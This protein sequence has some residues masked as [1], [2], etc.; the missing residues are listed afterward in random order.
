MRGGRS[1]RTRNPAKAVH[2]EKAG[3]AVAEAS[4]PTLALGG[5]DIIYPNEFTRLGRGP[6][7]SLEFTC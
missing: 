3:K 5:E 1:S 2:P 7:S 6:R 4:S